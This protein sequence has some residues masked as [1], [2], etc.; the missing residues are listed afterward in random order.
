MSSDSTA[1]RKVRKQRIPLKCDFQRPCTRTP[2]RGSKIKALQNEL[3][4]LKTRMQQ[5]H[6]RPLINP[7]DHGSAANCSQG[8]LP[9][10]SDQSDIS[11]CQPFDKFGLPSLWPIDHLDWTT[12]SLFN[13]SL[14]NELSF[15]QPNP[16]MI[17]EPC[18][19]LVDD[20]DHNENFGQAKFSDIKQADFVTACILTEEQAET[21]IGMFFRGCGRYF[22]FTDLINGSANKIRERSSVLFNTMCSLGYRAQQGDHAPLWKSLDLHVSRMLDTHI[23]SGA[24]TVEFIQALLIRACYSPERLILLSMATRMAIEMGLPDAY[25]EIRK[26]LI[27]GKTQLAHAETVAWDKTLQKLRTWLFILVMR[28]M[29]GVDKGTSLDLTLY[30][31]VR[32]CRILLGKPFSTDLDLCL[33]EQI[34]LNVLM[35]KINCSITEGALN[36]GEEDLLKIV[37]NAAV[38]IDVWFDDWAYIL[39]SQPHQNWLRLNIKVQRHWADI[40]ILCWAIHSLKTD[41]L[42]TSSAARRN[43][44]L[45]AKASLQ[46]HLKTI[47]S[48]PQLYIHNLRYA[49]DY[50]WAKFVYC[51][52]L[53]LETSSV[54]SDNSND[55]ESKQDLV[56]QGYKLLE[57][58]TKADGVLTGQTCSHVSQDYLQLLRSGIERFSQSTANLPKDQALDF[59]SSGELLNYLP[60]V[61]SS[62]GSFV[63]DH[64]A[65]EWKFPYPG[66]CIY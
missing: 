5:N 38:D 40:T 44:Q 45:M 54:T 19:Q 1:S 53:L 59:C 39:N 42:A 52:L 56:A 11:P 25:D 16:S 47:L 36:M 27:L 62:R 29:L 14:M 26:Q 35:A 46:Q 2:S 30:G 33:L 22:P 12:P 49:T 18:R 23:T 3:D 48:E 58:L 10:F 37:Q 66:L 34:E 55:Q 63:S 61:Q 28:L 51:F 21:Y 4:S 41:Y 60:E 24:T 15:E 8:E 7:I 64:F 13:Q 6:S 57:E 9:L 65:I 32:R 43:V 17:V 20:T 50:V 31:D